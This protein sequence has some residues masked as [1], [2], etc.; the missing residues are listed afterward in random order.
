MLDTILLYLPNNFFGLFLL[1]LIFVLAFLLLF[2]LKKSEWIIY[3]LLIW[4]PLESLILMYTPLDYYAQVKYIPE[5]IMYGLVFGTWLSFIIR[6]HKFLPKQPMSKWLMAFLAV[7]VVSL[8]L[9]FYSPWI[10]TLGL[11]QILRFVLIIFVIL[12]MNYDLP[13][14]KNILRVGIIIFI[15]EV[16]LGLVQYLSGGYLDAYLFSSRT[17]TVANMATLGG[18]EQ[19]WT[20]GSRVFATLGRYDQLGSFVA[21]GIILLFTF[22]FD[23][24]ILK[25]KFWYYILLIFAVFVLYL[26]KSRASWIAAFLG[27]STIGL[28]LYKSKKFL[29]GLF[30]FLSIFVI[31]LISFAISNQNILAISDKPNQSLGERV[32]ESFS[33]QGLRDSYDGYGRIFFIINTPLQVVRQY[34]LFGVGPGQYGG[35][36]AAALLHTDMYDRLHLPFGIQNIYG[37]IDNNWMSIWGEFGT[38]GLLVWIMIFVTV[39]KMSLFVREKADNDF[40]KNLAEGL[41]GLTVGIMAIGFFGPYFEFR[42]LMFY[43]WITVGVVGTFYVK[44]RIL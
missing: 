1:V 19:F 16:F 27:V 2:R 8:L 9:N 13:V 32:F 20:Q 25:N 11:R 43:Y 24:K 10:W 18:I 22:V 42:T 15:L 14:I 41:I 38:I 34:P 37:Q 21:L 31:Y 39:I 3:L 28:F 36:V 4:F 33:P 26:T 5:I 44:T 30:I 12:W 23:N 29:W 7:A 6:E 35:G 40:E 17:V